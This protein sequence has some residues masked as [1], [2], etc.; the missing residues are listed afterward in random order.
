MLKVN[1]NYP[2][3]WNYFDILPV[4]LFN[5]HRPTNTLLKA[6]ITLSYFSFLYIPLQN[7]L[8]SLLW[9]FISFPVLA[10]STRPQAI[11]GACQDP[12]AN[13]WNI[14]VATS[15][16]SVSSTGTCALSS[17]LHLEMPQ[18]QTI[19]WYLGWCSLRKYLSFCLLW[20]CSR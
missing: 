8:D 14:L 2:K 4:Y 19:Y 5:W 13:P 11:S 15:G 12:D 18:G 1:H 6:S 16:L 20:K 17:E 10:K 9:N 7:Y 3:P